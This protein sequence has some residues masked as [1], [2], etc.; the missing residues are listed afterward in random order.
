LETR[1]RVTSELAVASEIEGDRPVVEI[2]PV[3]E[4]TETGPGENALLSPTAE[5]DAVSAEIVATPEDVV[6]DDVVSLDS[7]SPFS[8]VT[9]YQTSVPSGAFVSVYVVASAAAV[10]ILV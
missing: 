1:P 6:I 3:V 9:A 7:P 10:S 5:I 2:V 8:A 4:A